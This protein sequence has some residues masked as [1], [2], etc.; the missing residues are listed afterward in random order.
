MD[1]LSESTRKEKRN[2]LASGFVGLIV[3]TLKILPE[4]FETLGIKFSSTELPVVFII[5]LI[6]TT[7][8]FWLK[9]SISYSYE[10]T[11]AK[12]DRLATQI[13]EG[14]TSLDI[15]EQETELNQQALALIQRRT[16][17]RNSNHTSS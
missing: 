16:R 4:E 13:R 17:F 11:Q 1:F 7:A 6:A 2:L 3:S 15:S 14:K 12:F 10:R 5:G 8:Y 9:F